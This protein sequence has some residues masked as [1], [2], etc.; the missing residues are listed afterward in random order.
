MADGFGYRA[1]TAS[2]GVLLLRTGRM[3]CLWEV[4]MVWEGLV[5]AVDL[6]GTKTASCLVARD[7]SCSRTIIRPTPATAGPDAVLDQVATMVNEVVGRDGPTGKRLLGVGVGSAGVIDH[8]TGVV[9]SATEALADWAGTD[10][11]DDLG[12]RLNG[13]PVSV[14]ND[15]NAHAAGEAWLGAARGY[16]RVLMA[17]VGTGVGG[18]LIVDGKPVRGVHGFAGEMGHVPVPGAEHLRCACGRLGHVEAISAGPGLLHH[19]YALGG[20]RDF[21]DPREIVAAVADGDD[22]AARAVCDSAAALGRCLAGV[23]TIIDPDVI[24]IGGGMAD[25]ILGAGW[26]ESMECTLRRELVD[27]LADV[28]LRPNELGSQAALLGAAQRAWTDMNDNAATNS[29]KGELS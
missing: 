4:V 27:V 3:E 5:A 19:F 21:A 1:A 6:G 12:Q 7:G 13:L 17:A 20:T 22:V 29:I 26:W 8:T 15:V 25:T 23:V 18:A 9:V 11:A 16:S 28:T 10:I 2:A 14:E 24:V